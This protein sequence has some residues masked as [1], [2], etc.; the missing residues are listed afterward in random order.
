MLT[1]DFDFNLPKEKIANQPVHPKDHSRLM[2]I[3]R[4]KKKITDHFFYELKDILKEGDL[5]IANDSK[6]LTAKIYGISSLGRKIEVFLV[7]VINDN[8][9]EVLIKE[10][11]EEVLDFAGIR[12][13]IKK[14]LDNFEI[15]FERGGQE[16]INH[17]YNIGEIP[18]SP[19][20]KREKLSDK[21]KKDYQTIFATKEGS[22]AAPTAGL[23]FTKRLVRE[24]EEKGI[25]LELVTFH[26]GIGA[27][28]PVKTD[29][30]QDHKMRSES[31]YISRQTADAV[32][33][34]KKE[35]RRIIAVGT[36]S[37]R[38]LEAASE[39]NGL[40]KTGSGST[41]IFIYPGYDFKVVNGMIT[42]FH[43]P[44]STLIILVSAFGGKNLVMGAYKKA[45]EGPYRFYNYGDAMILL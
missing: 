41:D 11:R 9:W 45:L 13:L 28:K 31:Y 12:G 38:A 35:G 26:V 29:V 4:K 19:Y 7:K 27:F 44:K 30:I 34:A 23:H 24:L 10:G 6:V 3:D 39:D 42:N 2:V 14:K 43:L 25:D 36:T 1:Q 18:L 17:I 22:V 16:L 5:L 21:D 32:N 15:T 40:I 37:L 20:I 33:K 8:S